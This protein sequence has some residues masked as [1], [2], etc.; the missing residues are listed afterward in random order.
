[1]GGGMGLI[2]LFVIMPLIR[3]RILKAE[4]LASL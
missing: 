4:E 3:R 2:T 1:V